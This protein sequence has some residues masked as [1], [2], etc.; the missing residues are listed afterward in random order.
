MP[1]PGDLPRIVRF[2]VFEVDLRAGELRRQGLKIKLQEKPYQVLALLL[3]Y[4]G[5]LVTREAFRE[6][7]WPADVIV[8]FEQS[9][10]TALK[11]LRHALGDTAD[12]PRFIETVPLR[13]YRFI[14]PVDGHL[15][16]TPEVTEPAVVEHV[17]GP[18]QVRAPAAER[19]WRQVM[20]W[21][22]TA[23]LAVML[24]IALW[25]PWRASPPAQRP[26]SRVVINL[27]QG[28]T[29]AGWGTGV[30]ISPDGKQ[31]AY[32]A[33]TEGASQQLYVRRLNELE[34]RPIPGTEGANKATFSPDGKWL[35]FAAHGALRKVSLSGGQPQT[36]CD[37]GRIGKGWY[38][39]NAW[40]PNGDALIFG[41][42]SGLLKVSAPEVHPR[43]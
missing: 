19:S 38:L 13:G 33:R 18:S 14:Y 29:F 9:L 12:N 27:P 35:A 16:A 39:S 6:R 11:K 8:E 26:V 41:S 15:A 10:N 28:Q 32:I 34:S 3:E 17:A 40:T 37:Y 2:G 4:H 36:L 31:I 23:L 42:D 5:G 43:H 7:L 25:S 1:E 24:G 20:P 21:G 22:L 30:E